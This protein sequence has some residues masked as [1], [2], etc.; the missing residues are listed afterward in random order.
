MRVLSGQAKGARLKGP[1]GRQT[2]RPTSSRVKNAIFNMV[3]GELVEGARVLDAYAGTGALGIEALSRGA[4]HVDF[5]ERDTGLCQVI[6]E[7]LSA[8]GLESAAHVYCQTLAKAVT[9]LQD[10]YDLAFMDPPYADTRIGETIALL[11]GSGLLKEGAALVVE[12]A[13]RVALPEQL[14]RMALDRTRVHGD[15]AISIYRLGSKG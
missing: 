10:S 8:A 3:A 4:G 13:S 15:T 5:V 11:G 14:G 7:N 9:F 6:R 12:H 2:A 1:R